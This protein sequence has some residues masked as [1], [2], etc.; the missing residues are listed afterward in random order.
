LFILYILYFVYNIHNNLFSLLAAL[1]SDNYT[2]LYF[3][4]PFFRPLMNVTTNY[5]RTLIGN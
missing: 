5:N 4:W 3:I 2:V 1:V